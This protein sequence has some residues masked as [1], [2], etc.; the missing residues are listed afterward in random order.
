MAVMSLARIAQRHPALYGSVAQRLQIWSRKPL[1]CTAGYR[2]HDCAP[3]LRGA[4]H[5]LFPS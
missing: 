2:P 1:T 4:V 3:A 5:R